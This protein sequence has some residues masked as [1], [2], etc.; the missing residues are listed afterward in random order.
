MRNL[1]ARCAVRVP[2]C[3]SVHAAEQ[4][5]A[6]GKEIV[7]DDG[8]RGALWEEA[9]SILSIY[10]L[11]CLLLVFLLTKDVVI[12]ILWQVTRLRINKRTEHTHTNTR[13]PPERNLFLMDWLR[14]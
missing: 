10:C 3:C 2:V 11:H 5:E 7:N 1:L 14:N 12:F 4:A 13:T 8:R 9:Y 6:D